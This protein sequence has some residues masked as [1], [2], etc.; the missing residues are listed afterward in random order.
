M[1]NDGYKNVEEALEDMSKTFNYFVW[2]SVR[3]SR[4]QAAFKNR[5]DPGYGMTV[6]MYDDETS[7]FILKKADLLDKLSFQALKKVARASKIKT[8][9]RKK[10]ELYQKILMARNVSPDD[11]IRIFNE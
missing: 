8:H 6:C 3:C 2:Q 7:E 10:D 9:K 1:S 11:I 5:P 4:I